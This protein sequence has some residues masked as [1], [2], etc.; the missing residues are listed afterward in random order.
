MCVVFRNVVAAMAVVLCLILIA[1]LVGGLV[2]SV[3]FQGASGS[4]CVPESPRSLHLP[5][6][7]FATPDLCSGKV[8]RI[9][10]SAIFHSD[11]EIMASQMMQIDAPTFSLHC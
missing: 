11:L 10:L 5:E 8:L 7:I 1:A 9:F 3:H 4:T 2:V 6:V